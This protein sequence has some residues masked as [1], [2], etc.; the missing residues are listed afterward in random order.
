[1]NVT[2][3]EQTIKLRK[4]PEDFHWL[5]TALALGLLLTAAAC[6]SVTQTPTSPAAPILSTPQTT[7]PPASSTADPAIGPVDAPVTIVEYGDFG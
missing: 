5:L 1:V 6:A 3:L 2:V 7:A 4:W